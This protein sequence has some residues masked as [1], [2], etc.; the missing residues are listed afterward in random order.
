[1]SPLFSFILPQKSYASKR[2]QGTKN[3]GKLWQLLFFETFKN[4]DSAA[5]H[6]DPL[7]VASGAPGV[8][9][10]LVLSNQALDPFLY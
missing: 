4:H 10:L 2:F 7:T 8:H 5:R 9:I 1:M 6:L 3:T